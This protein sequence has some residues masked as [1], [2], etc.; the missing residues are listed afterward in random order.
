M[1]GFHLIGAFYTGCFILSVLLMLVYVYTYHRHYDIHISFVFVLVPINNLG[2]LLLSRAQS[3]EAAILAQK[4]LY[5]SASFIILIITLVVFS[6]C[7]VR[8]NRYVRLLLYLLSTVVFATAMQIGQTPYFYKSVA[9]AEA[10]GVTVLVKEYGP[11]HT[12][13]YVMVVVY[14]LLGMGAAVYSIFRKKQVS[15]RFIALVALPEILSFVSFFA[16]R[17]VQRLIPDHPEI[18]WIP[19]AYDIALV[20]FLIISHRLLLYDVSETVIDSIVQNGDT[21]V[22]SFDDRLRYLGSNETARRMFPILEKQK[23]DH[24]LLSDDACDKFREWLESFR[25]DHGADTYHYQTGEQTL[26]VKVSDLSDGRHKRGYQLYVTDDTKNQQYIDL[27]AKYNS[28]LKAEVAQK[29]AHIVEMHDNL[30]LSMAMMVESRDNSTGGHIRRTSECVRILIDE[31][32]KDEA[33]PLDDTFCRNIIKAA[34]MHDLGKIAVDD[35]VL[36]K[37]GRFTDEEFAVMK[38]HAAEGA[39]IVHEILKGTDDTDFRILAENVA[40]FHHERWDGSGYPDGLRGEEIPLEARIMAI[41]DVYDALVSKRVYK[42]RMS[43]EKADS[44]IMDG[45]GRHFDK[46]LQPYYVA[47]RP[48]LEHYYKELDA[49]EGSAAEI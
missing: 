48:R 47:A 3:L 28:D 40:H 1:G 17:A 46:R 35:A 33:F 5:V 24:T 38:T 4:F 20:I 15:N 23:V 13:F 8:L 21:G 18:E 31:M 45:M 11:M 12:L 16:G 22:V 25:K 49:A 44:I 10:N 2:Q 9:L 32:R 26:L 39:R 29:T 34:P 43:F 6:L 42:E 37:P 36:R 30:I 14:F 7:T 41:A 27:L 19:L